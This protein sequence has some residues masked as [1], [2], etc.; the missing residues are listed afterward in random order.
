MIEEFMKMLLS[1]S[2]SGTCLFLLVMMIVRLARNRLSR[3]WQYYIWLLVVLRFLVPV[4]FPNTVTG[5]LF[6]NVEQAVAG[7]HAADSAAGGGA[8]DIEEIAA[9]KAWS[10]EGQEDT[11]DKIKNGE[12]QPDKAEG[13]GPAVLSEPVRLQE[14]LTV[15]FEEDASSG[16]PGG[17][18]LWLFVIWAV[19]AFGLLMRKITVYQS[20]MR[21]LKS[22][23]VEVSDP[24]MLNLLAEAEEALGIGRT[25]ELYRNPMI[26]SPIMTGFFR[27]GIVMPDKKMTDKELNCVFTHELVHFK[28]RDM[29]YKWLV[30]VTICVHWFNPFVWLLGKEV[31]RRCELSC[32]EKVVGALSAQARKDYGD[33]LLSFRCV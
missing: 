12:G 22:G 16:I 11:A 20:Y 7:R 17:F 2:F 29:F 4:T 9:S 19:G 23:N 13:G 27:P 8:E 32:D 33:T 30:Q 26:A 1:L 18:L 6:Q 21:F 31:N 10:E 3:R 28:Y 14:E 5:Q 24:A 25:I 15:T